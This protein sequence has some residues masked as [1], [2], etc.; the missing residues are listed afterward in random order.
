MLDNPKR[1]AWQAAP[2]RA[3]VRRRHTGGRPTALSWTRRREDAPGCAG[4]SRVRPA[5]QRRPHSGARTHHHAARFCPRGPV[6][7]GV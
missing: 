5:G 3:A 7:Q 6:V 2:P 1:R 4:R